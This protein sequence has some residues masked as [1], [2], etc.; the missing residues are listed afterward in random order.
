[1]PR[2]PNKNV[3][4]VTLNKKFILIKKKIEKGRV[5]G[6]AIIFGTLNIEK[7]K[8]YLKIIQQSLKGT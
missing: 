7:Y 2:Q 4:C 5:C 3:T 6:V 1:L 8:N